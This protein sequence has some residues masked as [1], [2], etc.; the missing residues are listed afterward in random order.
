MV[1]YDSINE[2]RKT[3]GLGEMA[4]LKEIKDAYLKLAHRY[5]PGKHQYAIE[6]EAV[7]IR[8]IN[9]AYKLLSDYCDNYKYSFHEEAVRLTYPYEEYVRNWYDNWFYSI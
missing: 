1:D 5:H 3:L 2:A 7:M 8:Q 6:E 9:K 4:T